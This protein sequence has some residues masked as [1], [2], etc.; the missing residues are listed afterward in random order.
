M[1]KRKAT[2][3][4]EF[5]LEFASLMKAAYDQNDIG[6]YEGVGIFESAKFLYIDLIYNDKENKNVN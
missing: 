2:K 3:R 1:K 4:E 6:R 5:I